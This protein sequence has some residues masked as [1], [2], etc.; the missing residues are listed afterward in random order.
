M[1][2]GNEK[3]YN[4]KKRSDESGLECKDPSLTVQSDAVDA[5]INTIVRR[6]GITGKLPDNF[7]L[8]QYG[9]FD[10]VDDFL[11][12][13][14]A[15]AEGQSEFMKIP[16]E[17]RARF[18]N[19]PAKFHDFAIDPDNFGSLVELGLATAPLPEPGNPNPPESSNPAPT[20]S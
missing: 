7:R 19:D 5:D 8:P 3:L 12:A 18:D 6:F 14:I 1:S 16:A 11:S 4:F 10:D 15:I 13:Q 9:D 20:P 2:D 17:V